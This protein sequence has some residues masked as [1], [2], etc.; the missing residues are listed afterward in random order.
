MKTQGL[1]F[2]RAAEIFLVKAGLILIKRNFNSPYGEIDLIMRDQNIL[3][4]VEVRQRRNSRFYSAAASVSKQKRSRIIK[5][6][7]HYLQ[8]TPNHQ[9]LF[10]RF[11]I[12]AYSNRC[13]APLWLKSAFTD[14]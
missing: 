11:D 13:D 2:E 14:E 3:V 10:C 7:Q 4:F 6:A 8:A 1:I 9:N 12:I 5:T